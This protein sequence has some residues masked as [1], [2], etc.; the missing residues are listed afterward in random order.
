MIAGNRDKIKVE[1]VKGKI[2]DPP[3]CVMLFTKAYLPSLHFYLSFLL[4]CYLLWYTI[5]TYK[6]VYMPLVTLE[7]KLKTLPQND[8]DEVSSFIDYLNCKKSGKPAA[9]KS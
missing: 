1:K 9:F 7:E 2:G 5:N 6:D 8:L 3:P 4:P